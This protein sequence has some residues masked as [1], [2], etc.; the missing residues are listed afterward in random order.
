MDS[1]KTAFTNTYAQVSGWP[2]IGPIPAPELAAAAFAGALAFDVG[3][4]ILAPEQFR[5]SVMVASAC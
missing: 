2:V 5:S 4:I 3:G 1:A